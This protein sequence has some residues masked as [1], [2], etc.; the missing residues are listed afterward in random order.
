[1]N[2]CNIQEATLSARVS[3]GGSSSP[4]CSLTASRMALYNITG[5]CYM[6]ACMAIW[7]V[8]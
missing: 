7:L 4:L 5:P 8:T 6:H 3:E 2:G 1:M